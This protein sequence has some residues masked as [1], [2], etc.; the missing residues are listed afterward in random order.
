MQT[1]KE[2]IISYAAGLTNYFRRYAENQNEQARSF[3]WN[4]GL[5]MANQLLRIAQSENPDLEELKLL[6]KVLEEGERD[7]GSGWF[8]MTLQARY[9][10]KFYNQNLSKR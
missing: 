4:L 7:F 8:D 5:F 3:E 9:L 6:I 10:L 2:K 1:D